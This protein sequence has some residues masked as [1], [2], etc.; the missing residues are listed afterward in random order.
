MGSLYIY[1]IEIT[2][3]INALAPAATDEMNAVAAPEG[4]AHLVS[5]MR[6]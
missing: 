4:A 2:E 3:P 6:V 1:S 5:Y